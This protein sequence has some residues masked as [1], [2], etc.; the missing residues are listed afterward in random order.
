MKSETKQSGSTICKNECIFFVRWKIQNDEC[1]WVRGGRGGGG[2]DSYR[3]PMLINRWCFVNFSMCVTVQRVGG[4]VCSHHGNGLW[5]A[6][7]RIDAFS[8]QIH[9]MMLYNKLSTLESRQRP[10]QRANERWNEMSSSG[11]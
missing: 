7:M 10:K 3:V 4:S 2:S 11:Q 5:W 9:I 1:G 6:F 8:K